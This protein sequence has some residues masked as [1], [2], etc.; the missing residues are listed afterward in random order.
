MQSTDDQ[1]QQSPIPND[2]AP[3]S[4]SAIADSQK[5]NRSWIIPSGIHLGFLLSVVVYSLVLAMFGPF[6]DD[7]TYGY[8]Y[9]AG[10][11]F[12]IYQAMLDSANFFLLLPG[13]IVSALSVSLA[14]KNKSSKKSAVFLTTLSFYISLTIYTLLVSF[15]HPESFTEGWTSFYGGG[16]KYGDSRYWQTI[17]PRISAH[18]MICIGV[19][20][21]MVFG[22]ED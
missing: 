6:G 19:V 16:D 13:L 17:I 3:V 10:F 4:T 7:G 15:F 18:L 1:E 5:K 9:H 12:Q 14:L 11:G 21:I 2:S 20:L 22:K 8:G